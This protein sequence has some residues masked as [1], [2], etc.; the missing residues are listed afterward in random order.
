VSSRVSAAAVLL[1]GG[2][3]GRRSALPH[4]RIV[5]HQPFT[6]GQRGQISDLQIQAEEILRVRTE[7]EEIL[8]VHTNRETTQIR[9]E[10]ERDRVLTAK[11]ALDYGLIDHI[12]SPRALSVA[13]A[14]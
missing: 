6:Q 4:A 5:L 9:T 3:A 12:I 14:M 10:I 11:E 1:A 13:E 2:T 7:L 8:S